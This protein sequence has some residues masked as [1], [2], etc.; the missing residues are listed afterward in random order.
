VDQ[1]IFGDARI[2]QPIQ[3]AMSGAGTV[4]ARCLHA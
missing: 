1:V 3:R 4:I 2:A